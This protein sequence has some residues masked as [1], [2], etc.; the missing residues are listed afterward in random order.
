MIISFEGI[1]GSG[2]STQANLLL[3]YFLHLGIPAHLTGVFLTDYGKDVRKLFMDHP[4]TDF[5]TQI[6]LLASAM[7]A[8]ATEIKARSEKV[9]ILDRYIHTT[10]SYHGVALGVG[11]E[12][13]SPIYKLAI[14]NI[15]PDCVILLDILPIDAHSRLPTARDRI[16]GFSEIFY[17]KARDGYLLM[18]TS[19]LSFCVFDANEEITQLHSKIRRH[20]EQTPQYQFVVN[21]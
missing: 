15:L 17:T 7:R 1:D 11:I 19:D 4:E 13:I 6:F 20:I 2:K 9:I 21:R 8:V 18:A 10:Y 16:E 5:K 3:N 14:E 12:N